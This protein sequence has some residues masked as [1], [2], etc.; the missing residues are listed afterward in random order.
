VARAGEH[1]GQ[2]LQ[3]GD[4]ARGEGERGGE[5]RAVDVL[6]VDDDAQ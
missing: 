3:G 6:R 4:A 1:G 5:R 2:R